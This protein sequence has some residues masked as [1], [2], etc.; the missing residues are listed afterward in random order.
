MGAP[1]KAA[2]R[3]SEVGMSHR[4][5]VAVVFA[6]V[7]ALSAPVAPVSALA[8][9]WEESCVNTPFGKICVSVPVPCESTD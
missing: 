3:E 9:C 6:V 7:M 2:R 5:I 8:V 4:R 1:V